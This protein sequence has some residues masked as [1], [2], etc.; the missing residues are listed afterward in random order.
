MGGVRAFIACELSSPL[1]DAIEAATA[2]LRDAVG[3]RLV[4]WVQPRNIH[5]TLKFLGD[6][7]PESMDLVRR[8]VEKVAGGGQAFD[9]VVEDIGA[10]PNA[11]RPRVLWV[12]VQAAPELAS[13]QRQLDSV[14]AELGFKSEGRGYVPHLTIG[15]TR[16][17]EAGYREEKIG[18]GLAHARVGTLGT[19][20][21]G[22]IHLFK[23]D[24]QRTGPVYT[25]LLTAPLGR[26]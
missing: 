11:R 9:M 22:A 2:S 17:R 3:S 13:L 24:L 8:A 6:V 25:K 7:S 5:L 16:A 23:S 12:G 20:H 4:R 18:D 26:S 15:Y 14:T 19:Q 10:F 1:Q 21:V